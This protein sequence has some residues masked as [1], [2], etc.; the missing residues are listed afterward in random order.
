MR[1][2]RVV[3][4]LDCNFGWTGTELLLGGGRTGP[5]QMPGTLRGAYACVSSSGAAHRLVRDPLGLAKLFWGINAEGE[6]CFSARPWRLVE[7]GCLFTEI[8]AVPPGIAIDLS[9]NGGP[10]QAQEIAAPRRAPD[11]G[12]G[13][14]IEDIAREIRT[15]VDRYC[16]ALAAAHPDARVFVCL[17]GGLDST[18]VA[19]LAR[20]HFRDVVVVS[21]DLKRP[22]GSTSADRRTAARLASDW[23][24]PFLEVTSSEE[25]VLSGLDV[26]LR[27]AIDW[28]DF[29]IH[30]ALVN[31]A[32]ASGIAG[33]HSGGPVLV[34]TG[35]FPNE[36]LVDYHA[37]VVGGKTYYALPRL[38]PG[39]LQSTLVRGLETS[40]REIGPFQKWRL[41]VVQV[42]APAVDQY[43][44]LPE[45]FLGEPQRKERLTQLIFGDGIPE[46]VYSRP[47]TRAQVG[48]TDSG[49]GV[50][51]LC[52]KHGID[53]PQLRRR[54]AD[55]HG[56]DDLSALDRFIRAGRYRASPPHL[57]RAP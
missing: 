42:Y 32:L 48:D 26:A 4:K 35:D 52:L 6:L 31:I 43:L 39:A 56:V 34:L 41:P 28:R 18:G 19:V 49:A 8:Q 24:L 22:D 21:F 20:S 11:P 50:L 51:G 57:R 38:S 17:S 2:V 13:R 5:V 46:Y 25:E 27:E 3:G 23:R 40:H 55:L 29:N 9:T 14:P 10:D 36:Y 1:Q 54:F 12:P 53:S 44:A 15:T 47:K 33:A 45:S 7:A 16:A 37:E 30:A